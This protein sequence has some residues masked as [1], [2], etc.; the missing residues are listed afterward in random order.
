ML[1]SILPAEPPVW[2][3]P[4]AL[5]RLVVTWRHNR[6]PALLSSGN[7]RAMG[8]VEPYSTAGGR[9]YRVRYRDPER[10]TKAKAGFRTRREAETFLASVS[11]AVAHGAYIDPGDAKQ[12]VGALGPGW[13]KAQ[14]HLKPSSFAPLETAWRVYVEPRWGETE[15]GRIRHSDVQT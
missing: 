2:C 6:A 4:Q 13:L 8:S 15:V 1:R 3:P 11:L 5:I 7:H 12:T 14:T 10:R 9:R